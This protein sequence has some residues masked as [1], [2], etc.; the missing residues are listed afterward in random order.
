[1]PISQF[2]LSSDEQRRLQRR[3]RGLALVRIRYFYIGLLGIVAVATGLA[4]EVSTSQLMIYG[5]ISV[6]G[7]I[8]N[9]IIGIVLRSPSRKPV[10]YTIG[11][12]AAVILDVSLATSVVFVLGGYPARATLLY[13]VPILT[14]GV[15]LLQPSAYIA[16]GLSSVS[17]GAV[18]LYHQYFNNDPSE[19]NDL[20]A[21][22]FFYPVAFFILAAIVTQFSAANAI[23]KQEVS[24]G[25]MLGLIRQQLKQPLTAIT[26]T[27]KTIENDPAYSNLSAPQQQHL[28]QLAEE[29]AQ[30]QTTITQLTETAAAQQTDEKPKQDKVNV[31]EI[32]RSAAQNCALS[33]ARMADLHL[34][35]KDNV[36]IHADSK[37]LHS[38]IYNIIDNA[39]R[40]SEVGKPIEVELNTQGR[41]VM[42]TITDQG[43]GMN[44][45]QQRV[46]A[47]RSNQFENNQ[48]TNQAASQLSTTGLGLHVSKLIIERLGGSIDLFSKPH[49][50]TKV[51]IKLPSK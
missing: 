17:Y 2:F 40:Y 22:L 6:V 3:T 7:L 48:A 24:Y 8:T 12:Y 11:T 31:T 19:F 30:L 43:R 4:A 15:L 37:Q 45:E 36:S 28:K 29:S 34:S 47:M 13:A 25:Q 42:I 16:A 33:A 50:G 38:A 39:F 49:V 46:N 26:T 21:P 18:L 41:N 27:I 14:S 10:A 51:T 5:S 35:L 9:T 23:N 44:E 20:F 1:M 32:I